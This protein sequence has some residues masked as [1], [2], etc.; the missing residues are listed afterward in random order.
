MTR[1]LWITLWRIF[2]N[3]SKFR[4]KWE[5]LWNH[6]R[7]SSLSHY[8]CTRT[9]MYLGLSNH[10]SKVEPAWESRRRRRPAWPK[11]QSWAPARCDSG[12]HRIGCHTSVAGLAGTVGSPRNHCSLKTL[13]IEP[14]HTGNDALTTGKKRSSSIQLRALFCDIIY[15]YS[16]LSHKLA[17]GS[18]IPPAKKGVQQKHYQ[19]GNRRVWEGTELLNRA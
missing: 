8:C 7:S 12:S 9:S 13:H 10:Y 16:T 4:F 11:T 5:F 2:Y 17:T 15:P 6:L 1:T 3:A 19:W 18:F 14:Y